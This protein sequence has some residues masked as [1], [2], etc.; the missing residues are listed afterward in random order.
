M[1]ERVE[2]ERRAEAADPEG[3]DRPVEPVRHVAEAQ[4]LTREEADGQ[5]GEREESELEPVR[6]AR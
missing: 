5:E 3:G 6:D 1:L 4:L 2:G